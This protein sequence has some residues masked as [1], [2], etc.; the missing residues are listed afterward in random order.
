MPT[1]LVRLVVVG[2]VATGLAGCS[3]ASANDGP[4]APDG[5]SAAP[6]VDLDLVDLVAPTV[7]PEIPEEALEQS[8]AGAI[9]FVRFWFDAL[10]YSLSTN[11]TELLAPWTS[12]NCPQCTSWL[13]TITG[14]ANA[15][16]VM[17]GGLTAPVTLA[18]GPFSPDGPVFFAATFVN[19][20]AV[21]TTPDGRREAY[22]RLVSDGTLAI[23]WSRE[24]QRWLMSTVELQGA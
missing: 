2:L 9:A 11:D 5:P 7:R 18:I 21:V 8:E 22:P 23:E 24:S 12:G 10:N 14:N 20:E 1:R 6:S 4:E 13:I 19:E 16:A 3:D 15:D 17:E